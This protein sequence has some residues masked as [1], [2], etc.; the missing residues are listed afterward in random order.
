MSTYEDPQV[1]FQGVTSPLRPPSRVLWVGV[2]CLVVLVGEAALAAGWIWLAILT[3]AALALA[4]VA[5]IKES[6]AARGLA[7]GLFLLAIALGVASGRM[8]HVVVHGR[9][10]PFEA[11][12]GA[13]A[14]RDR[15]L[16]S[17]V[18]AAG[19]AA[20]AALARVG[21]S[22]PEDAPSLAD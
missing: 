15:V 5:W 4:A 10:L 2:A 12:E 21:Q 17:A 7:S 11:A 13:A 20:A 1:K 16:E 3:A 14:D 22:R 6:A 8:A 18:A 9:L 19:R